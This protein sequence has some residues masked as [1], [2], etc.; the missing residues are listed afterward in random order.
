[1]GGKR[2]GSEERGHNTP[3]AFG[4]LLGTLATFIHALRAFISVFA[5]AKA[6]GELPSRGAPEPARPFCIP[7]E[8]REHREPRPGAV[9]PRRRLPSKNNPINTLSPSVFIGTTLRERPGQFPAGAGGRPL[10]RLPQPGPH[11]HRPRPPPGRSGHSPR[12]SP[13]A[14]IPWGAAQRSLTSRT[15]GP[16]PRKRCA[17]TGGS[18]GGSGR[19]HRGRRRGGGANHSGLGGEG[20][21]GDEPSRRG[22]RAVPLRARGRTG[23]APLGTRGQRRSRSGRSRLLHGNRDGRGDR[24]PSAGVSKLCGR[25]AGRK[26][27]RVAR[28]CA[29][30]MLRLAPSGA[31]S[32]G[33]SILAQPGP[34]RAVREDTDQR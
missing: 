31:V 6:A 7:R 32:R 20:S 23:T 17:N 11:P 3:Q 18:W 29:R 33:W 28:G 1:M 19:N 26:G 34:A 15:R 13:S 27:R 8:S 24:H 5:A 22:A 9:L 16:L 2:G 10:R 25:K 14:H 30:G 21:R 4:V 12:S